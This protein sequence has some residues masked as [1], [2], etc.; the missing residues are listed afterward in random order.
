MQYGIISITDTASGKHAD[1]YADSTNITLLNETISIPEDI[2]VD[3]VNFDRAFPIDKCSTVVIPFSINTANITGVG[4]ICEYDGI[5][6]NTPLLK[7]IYA[8]HDYAVAHN[9]DKTDYEHITLTAYKPYIFYTTTTK[10]NFTGPV[11]FIKTRTANIAKDGWVM[12]STLHRI[13]WRI[14]DMTYDCAYGFSAVT[15]P[16][17]N[18]ETGNLVRCSDGAS[19]KPL[20]AFLTQ[21]KTY[22]KKAEYCTHDKITKD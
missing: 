3:T 12:I 1:I 22:I 7:T 8:T 10:L 6:S 15:V 2:V 21:V 17:T 19:I 11:T 14:D 20:R 5:G 16:N 9:F 13:Q 18:I 4:A